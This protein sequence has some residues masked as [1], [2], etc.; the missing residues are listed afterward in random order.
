MVD[1]P[2]SSPHVRP[3]PAEPW[4]RSSWWRT[5]AALGLLGSSY[6]AAG[7]VGLLLAIGNSSVSAVWPPTGIAIAAL[8][9]GDS[10]L[11]PAIFVG[12][13]FVNLT[14]TWDV[15]S[16]LGIASGN[17]LEALV[18]AYLANRFAG[19]RRMFEQPRN[20]LLFA[21]L[22]GAG[23][24]AVAA[25]I[26]TTTLTLA[27]LAR[28]GAVLNVW[29]SWWL[30]DA[31]GAIEVAPLILALAPRVTRPRPVWGTPGRAEAGIVGAVT[32]A[33][34]LLVFAR[35]TS[36]VLGGYPLE[37]LVVPPVVWGATRFGTVG[38][39]GSV[40]AVSVIALVATVRGEGPFAAFP[41]DVALLALRV[42]IGSLVLTALL[43]AAEVTQHHRLETELYDA[44]K[45]L[46]QMLIERNS[47]LDAAKSLA[48]VGTWTLEAGSGKLVWSDEMYQI[49]GYGSARFPVVLGT[50][51]ERMERSDRATFL[52]E[53]RAVLDAPSAQ[54][55]PLPEH[56]YRLRLPNGERR[57]LQSQIAV[58][59]TI[60]GRASRLRGTVLDVTE[61][62][63]LED[64]LRR[65]KLGSESEPPPKD[66]LMWMIPWMKEEKP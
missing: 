49:F 12:A 47:Q 18:G 39:I 5:A 10:T 61:R 15:A 63:R 8:L 44:R 29:G 11:W 26:G 36:T 56:R 6:F 50:G 7:K 28:P 13:F 64:E 32:A 14:T 9:L 33:V 20:V 60:D 4:Y 23:A 55:V 16:S 37:F 30:G 45:A 58:S 66:F 27:H 54:D 41:P 3:R 21:L 17:T 42:F 38:A 19:G 59:E 48:T 2:P 52:A 53:L 65:L 31:I 57:A 46:Q 35:P 22:S 34:A 51:L 62:Q 24:A 40:S 1:M 25:T 43:V